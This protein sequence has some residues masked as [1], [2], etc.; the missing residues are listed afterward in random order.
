M[1]AVLVFSVST[2]F[3]VTPAL[4]GGPNEMMIGTQIHSDL[5]FNHK[6]GAGLAAAQGVVLA[7]L[8]GIVALATIRAG[9]TGFLK[10]VE[11]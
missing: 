2:G 7:L 8:L 9:G 11:K 5:V 3:F 1:A 10:T 4:L 6:D